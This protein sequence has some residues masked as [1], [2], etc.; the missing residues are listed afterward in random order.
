MHH[1]TNNNLCL[2]QLSLSLC[3]TDDSCWA[4]LVQSGAGAIKPGLELVEE[5]FHRVHLPT[6][7]LEIG[8]LTPSSLVKKESTLS[9]LLYEE[10]PT[11]KV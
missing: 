10:N 6:Q 7:R 8:S 11:I 2:L 9:I 1:V 4:E 3:L 5:V